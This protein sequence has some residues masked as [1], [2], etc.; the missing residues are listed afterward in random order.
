MIDSTLTAIVAARHCGQESSGRGSHTWDEIGAQLGMSADGVRGRYRRRDKGQFPTGKMPEICPICGGAHSDQEDSGSEA[1]QWREEGNYAELLVTT[2]ERIKSQ[3]DLVAAFGVDLDVWHCFFFEVGTYEGF[4]KREDKDLT[5]TSGVMDGHAKSYGLII[6]PMYRTKARF[7]RK[8]PK[9]LRP[10]VQP[11]ECPVAY[12]LPG[13][14]SHG[15]VKSSLLFADPHFG[16]R[17][18]LQT[19]KLDPFHS[20]RALDLVLQVAELEQPERIDMLGD[21]ADLP[22]WTDK[23]T[24]DVEFYFTTQPAVLEFHWFLRRL[25]EACPD[26]RIRLFEGNHDKRMR[27][28]LSNNL[29]EACELRAADEMHLPPALSPEK[30]LALDRLGIEW[31]GEYPNGEEW[32]GDLRLSH[33]AVARANPGDTAKAV[34]TKSDVHEAFGHVHRLELVSRRVHTREEDRTVTAMCPGCTCRIDGVVPG[35]KKSHDWQQGLALVSY[36]ETGFAPMFAEIQGGQV[37]W[38]DQVLVARDW[39][40]ALRE[41]LPGWHW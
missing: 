2:G 29:R 1:K 30:L 40:A 4:A 6:A 26:A 7:V 23:F 28:A 31:I 27:D 18:D 33:G 16:Y 8:E 15:G 19:G 12:P 39:L 20:R 10:V 36:T 34:A 5:F 17:R 24:R 11:V 35:A 37:I 25:R 14:V 13:P 41:D 22:M 32:L 9:P 21:G 38:R 3:D